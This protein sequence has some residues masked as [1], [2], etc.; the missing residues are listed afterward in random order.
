MGQI[1]HTN[2]G[3]VSARGRRLGWRTCLRKGCGRRFQARRH[4]QRYCR[5]PECLAELR[6]WQAAKR[7]HK[8]REGAEGR[9]QHVGGGRT[10]NHF[11]GNGVRWSA[12]VR[13]GRP[14]KKW[15]PGKQ[16]ISLEQREAAG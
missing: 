14:A 8:R 5:E 3:G 13:G 12:M 7:Q 9:Q 1:Q 6:R 10:A 2:A 11:A 15:R 16:L 4:N